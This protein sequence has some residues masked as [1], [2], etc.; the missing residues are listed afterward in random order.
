MTLPNGAHRTSANRQELT[1]SSRGIGSR[2]GV[3]LVFTLFV[4]HSILKKIVRYFHMESHAGSF[5][6]GWVLPQG[7]GF[8]GKPVGDSALGYPMLTMCL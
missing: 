3:A 2:G 1:L 7:R 8:E 5:V 4:L 6:S